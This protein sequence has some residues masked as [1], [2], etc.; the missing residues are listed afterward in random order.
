MKQFR[1]LM[2]LTFVVFAFTPLISA[3][4]HQPVWGEDGIITISNLVT[5]YA[6]YRDL[7]A[8]K[9]D[10]YT[11]EGKA[12]Q[13]LHAGMQI[14]AIKGLENYTVTM[15]LFGPGLPEADHDQLPAE[16]PED[17]GALIFQT[18]KGEDFFESFTQTTYWGRQSIE[19]TLPEDGIYYLIVWQPENIAG[20]YVM[21]TGSTESFGPDALFLFPVWWIRV[22][23]FF[24]H[25]V[26]LLA[27]AIILTAGAFIFLKRRNTK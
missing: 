2:I 25:G 5:S 10:V 23:L 24:D 1:I 27:G 14:P 17:L 19:T 11:F 26:Y 3:S 20:K 16:H 8:D 21:D 12:G 22:H 9:V 4:A 13:S 18:A 7:P 15:A 6:F